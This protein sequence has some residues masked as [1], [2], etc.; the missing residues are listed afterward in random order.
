MNTPKKT[1]EWVEVI[2]PGSGTKILVP[3]K[4]TYSPDEVALI[5]PVPNLK[6]FDRVRGMIHFE[7]RPG[8]AIDESDARDAQC[9]AGW[10]DTG[11]GFFGFHFENG[12][13]TWQSAAR[14]D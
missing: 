10:P 7:W 11:Y 2:S 5:H 6:A 8:E 14:C 1:I 12:L 13:A 4:P 3:K 9:R